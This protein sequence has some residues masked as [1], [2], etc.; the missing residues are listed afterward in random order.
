KTWI[1][2]FNGK[3]IYSEGTVRGGYVKLDNISVA[4]G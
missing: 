2:A 1:K 4:G 3:S